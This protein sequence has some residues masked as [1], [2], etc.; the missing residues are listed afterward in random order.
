MSRFFILDSGFCS[1]LPAPS[2]LVFLL[3][4]PFTP[5]PLTGKP[6]GPIFRKARHSRFS[7]QLQQLQSPPKN[8]RTCFEGPFGEVIRA[9]G[10]MA[11]AN[12]FRFSTKYQDDETDL[13]YYG[14]RYYSASAS[15]W[16]NRDPASEKAGLNLYAFIRNTPTGAR[17][18]LGQSF[19]WDP[20]NLHREPHPFTNNVPGTSTYT[21]TYGITTWWYFRPHAPVSNKDCP[22]CRYRLLIWGSATTWG[23]FTTPESLVHE[24]YHIN[25]HYYPAYLGFTGE[26]EGYAS[27]CMS[28]RKATCFSHVVENELKEKWKRSAELAAFTFDWQD[29]GSPGS[30]EEWEA[31]QNI[32]LRYDQATTLL[33]SALE[34]CNDIEE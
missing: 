20:P 21:V 32:Q 13:I 33:T 10:P 4:Q 19:Q 6:H 30:G 9:T 18:P 12:P 1:W 28:K 34:N 5:Q 26:A 22:P 25:F 27:T 24:A 15:R 8:P 7:P 3:H 2:G 11:K 16:I 31:L 23:W 17:D 14:Y 29:A